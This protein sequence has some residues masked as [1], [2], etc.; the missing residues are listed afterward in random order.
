MFRDAYGIEE[1]GK[2]VVMPTEDGLNH[3]T[4]KSVEEIL[5]TL[6]KYREIRRRTKAIGILGYLSEINLED[7]FDKEIS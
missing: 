7:E 6:N 2:V 5:K 3:K 1:S 4:E